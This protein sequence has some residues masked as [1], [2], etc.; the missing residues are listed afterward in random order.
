VEMAKRARVA[1]LEEANA[2]LQ[3]ELVAAR[4][5]VAEVESRESNLM[6]SYNDLCGDYMILESTLETLQ[7]EKAYFE[8]IE[9]DKAQRFHQQLHTKL[10]DLHQE[11]E[12]SVDELGG[13]CFEFPNTGGP[14]GGILDWF[15]MEVQALS[16]TFAE[17]NQNITCYAAAGILMMLAGTGCQ[18]LSLLQKLAVSSDGSL[19]HKISTDIGKM[20]GKLVQK[21]WTNHGLPYCMQHLEEDNQV[22][23]APMSFA[24]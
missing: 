1:E 12:K 9:R 20:I 6:S 3:A 22:S 14:I 23:F 24:I 8:K 19:L 21:W 10:H 15:K 2:Y 18:H 11:Q 17:A 5:R 4:A 13:Q 16:N 7:K